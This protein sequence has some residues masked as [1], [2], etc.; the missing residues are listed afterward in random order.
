ITPEKA[1]GRSNEIVH[2]CALRYLL[3]NRAILSI[4]LLAAAWSA[5]AQY[6]TERY[7][8]SYY[9]SYRNKFTMGAVAQK[10]ST[11][12]K[13]DAQSAAHSLRYL[14][15]SAGRLGISGSHDFLGLTA[16]VGAG[17]LDPSFSKEKGKTRQTNLQLRVT[18]RKVLAD[19]YFQKY[20]GLFANSTYPIATP[21][22]AYYIRPD[23]ET[24][25]YGATVTLIRNNRRFSAQ[26]SFLL[27]A[28][29]KKSAGS[30]LLG[31]EF[32]YGSAR[33]DSAFIPSLL[34][35]SYPH[36]DVSGLNFVSFGPG[37]GYGYTWV[38]KQHFFLTAMGSFNADIS[39]I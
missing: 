2:Y 33:G 13:T 8:T 31:G 1:A 36:A 29:Q 27:D 34:K 30:L 15:N 12:F 38:A 28:W 17:P 35:D 9:I 10:K 16:T 24:K 32:F 14:S 39:Y 18:G 21:G 25:L 5:N 11:V 3:M 20:K 22:S 26:A 23:I 37:A 19:I 4:I 7:D 6:R